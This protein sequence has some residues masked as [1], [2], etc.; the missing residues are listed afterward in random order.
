MRRRVGEARVARLA[1]VGAGGQPHL[2]PCC[3]VLEGDVVVTAVDDVKAK[4]TRALRRLENIRA[5][6][7][8]SLLVDHYGE[9]WSSL[10]W[11]RADGWASILEIGSAGEEAALQSLRE[12]YEQY[13]DDNLPGPVI[14]VTVTRWV[15]W[16]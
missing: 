6:P 2:V 10:W 7:A 8:V 9:D 4:S 5:Q 1:T 13:R 16:P 14:A 11:V 12:K 15:A 3:F